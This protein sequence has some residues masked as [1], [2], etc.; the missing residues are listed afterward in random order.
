MKASHMPSIIVDSSPEQLLLIINRAIPAHVQQRYDELITK[1][2]ATS[3]TPE[4]HAELLQLTDHVEL[5]NAERVAALAELARL[6]QTT[7]AELLHRFGIKPT[8]DP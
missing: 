3:L 4:E 1:R 5:L 8:P 2:R 6:R 7:L